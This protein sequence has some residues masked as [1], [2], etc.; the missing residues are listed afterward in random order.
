MLTSLGPLLGRYSSWRRRKEHSALGREESMLSNL[1][2][3]FPLT[4]MWD[5][6]MPSMRGLLP[7]WEPAPFCLTTL[8]GVGIWGY[9]GQ[10]KSQTVR[11]RQA[12]RKREQAGQSGRE[13]FITGRNKESD[14]LWRKT[15]ALPL[16][17]TLLI[18]Y[19]WE[20]CP[21]GRGP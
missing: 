13:R 15:S 3:C 14:W 12:W 17:P 2:L 6:V 1:S 20:L 18:P 9:L 8:L 21:E 10:E 4:I 19:W 7:A 16:Q 5:L 11:V